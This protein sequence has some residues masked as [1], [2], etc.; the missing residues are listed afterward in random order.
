MSLLTFDITDTQKT[1]THTLKGR[2]TS[3]SISRSLTHGLSSREPIWPSLPI[4][5]PNNCSTHNPSSSWTEMQSTN[6]QTQVFRQI[7]T[8]T[9][10]SRKKQ[11]QYNHQITIPITKLQY[12]IPPLSLHDI[13]NCTCESPVCPKFGPWRIP[14]WLRT[15]RHRHHLYQSPTQ[16]RLHCAKKVKKLSEGYQKPALW[17]SWT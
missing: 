6:A 17:C 12:P 11:L 14:P 13:R 16:T 4:Y 7:H 2:Q 8:H 5:I 10:T 3:E 1:S 9:H 15:F